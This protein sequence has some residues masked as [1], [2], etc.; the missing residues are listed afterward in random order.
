MNVTWGRGGKEKKEVYVVIWLAVKFNGA[1]QFS[2]YRICIFL[3][4]F[5]ARKCLEIDKRR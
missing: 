3:L 5:T 2:F 4:V 1:L